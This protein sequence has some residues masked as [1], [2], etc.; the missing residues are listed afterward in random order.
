MRR[1]PPSEE[2]EAA[3]ADV[4]WPG[5][6]DTEIWHFDAAK[7]AEVGFDRYSV[8]EAPRPCNRGTVHASGEDLIF[9]SRS[10]V[11]PPEECDWVIE[12]MDKAA[13]KAW[14]Q[15][16]DPN[17]IGADAIYSRPFPDRLW[18]RDMP[19]VKAWFD[20]RLKTRLFPMLQSLYPHIIPKPN[21]LR[22]HDAFIS[23]YDASRTASLEMHRDTTS[24]SFTIAMNRATDYEGGGTSLPMVRKNE[25]ADFAPGAVKTDIGGVVSFPGQCWHGG[26]KVESGA[27]YIIPLFIFLDYNKSGKDR[28]YVIDQ[29]RDAGA[30]GDDFE[31]VF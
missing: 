8:P 30:I 10:A 2:I 17:N 29:L 21:D 26:N 22:C 27:R 12:Q 28:G 23:R 1:I 6:D 13:E 16:K 19:G 5:Q 14:M 11:I 4:A 24:F 9:A 15:D 31:M 3:K 25:D 18:M 7:Q 20:H